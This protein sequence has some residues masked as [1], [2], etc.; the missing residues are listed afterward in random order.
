MLDLEGI[1]GRLADARWP[2]SIVEVPRRD[3]AALVAE[4]ERLTDLS[5]L[6][7]GCAGTHRGTGA[8]G[9]PREPHHHHDERCVPGMAALL[10][11]ARAEVERL[12]R[13][14]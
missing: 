13:R 9:R 7:W 5:R 12:R 6:Q 10:A 14:P 1:K 11:E 2:E 4:V 8:P 3:L